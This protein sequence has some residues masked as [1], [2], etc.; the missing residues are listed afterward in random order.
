MVGLGAIE[1]GHLTA[2]EGDH[3]GGEE[4]EASRE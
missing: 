3:L 4:I 1:E 2:E